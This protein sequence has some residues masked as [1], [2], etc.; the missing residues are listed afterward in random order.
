M[1]LPARNGPRIVCFLKITRIYHAHLVRQ[2]MALLK[3]AAN[4]VPFISRER[5]GEIESK[6]V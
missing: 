4:A 5:I 3:N 1:D 2:K 6:R